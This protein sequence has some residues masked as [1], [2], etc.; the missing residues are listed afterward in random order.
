MI[1]NTEG[2]KV[3]K[4]GIT[5]HKVGHDVYGNPRYVCHHLAL[6]TKEE[7]DNWTYPDSY[8]RAITRANKLGGRKYTAK[9]FGGGVVFS[10]YNLESLENRINE[11]VHK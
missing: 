1:V 3:K 10:S 11:E 5:W 9:W 7:K 4:D 8:Q 2:F 6:L